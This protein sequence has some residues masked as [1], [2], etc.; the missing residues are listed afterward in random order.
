MFMSEKRP[1]HL[2][3][4]TLVNCSYRSEDTRKTFVKFL[5]CE[6]LVY[7]YQIKMLTKIRYFNI[8]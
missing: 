5:L 6:Y 2:V 1:Y 7:E 4:E 8:K 3:Q